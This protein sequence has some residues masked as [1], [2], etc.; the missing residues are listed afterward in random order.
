MEC[1]FSVHSTTSKIMTLDYVMHTQS[2]PL[3][4]LMTYPKTFCSY[5]S[6]TYLASLSEQRPPPLKYWQTFLS[7]EKEPD[8][9]DTRTLGDKD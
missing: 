7:R 6:E 9:H 3:A 2:Q 5:F 4:P 1:G 8:I